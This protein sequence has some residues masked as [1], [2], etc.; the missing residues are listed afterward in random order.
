MTI[1]GY[2]GRAGN[3]TL[4][5]DQIVKGIESADVERRIAERRE[6]ERSQEN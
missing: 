2:G 3:H 1:E 5:F 6:I 4:D